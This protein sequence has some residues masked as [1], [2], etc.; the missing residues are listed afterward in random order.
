M[1][2]GY[3]T[4]GNPAVRTQ[5][6][7]EQQSNDISNAIDEL[8]SALNRL[9]DRLH[10]ALQL[11]P[12]CGCTEEEKDAQWVPMASVLRLSRRRVD[13]LRGQVEDLLNRLEL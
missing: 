10:L 8:G 12:P 11:P 5:G 1:D 3:C 7:I 4:T 2:K 9:E 6:Q 13:G